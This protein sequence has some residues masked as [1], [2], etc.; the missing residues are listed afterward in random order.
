MA[1]LIGVTLITF[2]VLWPYMSVLVLA[3][4]FAIIFHPVYMKILSLTRG[5]QAISAWITVFLVLV[6]VLTPLAFLG[7]TI[8]GQ[9]TNLYFTIAGSNLDQLSSV[10]SG[11]SLKITQ[12][13]HLAPVSVNFG[14]YLRQMVF[15][16]LQNLGPLFSSLATVLLYVFLGLLGLFYLLKDGDKF[17][18][19]LMGLLPLQAEYSEAIF[20]RLEHTVNS[21]I[22]G[23][24][25]IAL[26][27]GCVAGIGFTIFGVPNAVFW[28]AMAAIT[29]LIPTFGTSLVVVPSMIYLFLSGHVGEALGLLVWG[30]LAV[31][32]I[33]NLLSPYVMKRGMAIHPFFILLSVLG[34]ITVFGP[35]GFLVGPLLLSLFF[36]LLD[37]YPVFVGKIAEK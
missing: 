3:G 5:R 8:F 9:A 15:W 14:E 28:G 6:L 12:A 33:D 36:S 17:K 35:I 32:L 31:G 4:T 29:A 27:Q 16:L 25:V 20:H 2:Y 13:L 19:K 37:I 10:I 21:V 7:F 34:G 23:T 11:Y 26:I 18:R 30:A 1:L 22:R 24:L